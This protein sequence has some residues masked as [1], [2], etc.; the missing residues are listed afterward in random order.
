MQDKAESR[1]LSSQPTPT[2]Q[3]HQRTQGVHSSCKHEYVEFSVPY[4]IHAQQRTPPGGS[5][6]IVSY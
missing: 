4:H 5:L 1:G 2:T 3:H 6:I